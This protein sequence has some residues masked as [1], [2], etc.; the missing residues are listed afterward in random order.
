VDIEGA[1]MDWEKN[2][3][4]IAKISTILELGIVSKSVGI[5]SITKQDSQGLGFLL[6]EP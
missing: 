6:A 5:Q 2:S 3:V 1:Q 4:M